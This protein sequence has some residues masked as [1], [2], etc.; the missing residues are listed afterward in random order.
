M[1]LS[2]GDWCM[3]R[4]T[5]KNVNKWDINNTNKVHGINYNSIMVNIYIYNL[6][7]NIRPIYM[8]NDQRKRPYS[9]CHRVIW[10]C[11][12]S[13]NWLIFRGPGDKGK[14]IRKAIIL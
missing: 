11:G 2:Y 6:I 9:I 13:K 10:K 7:H 4:E 5:E 3:K 12:T 1:T 14:C 8:N